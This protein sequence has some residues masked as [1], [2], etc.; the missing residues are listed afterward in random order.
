MKRFR[1]VIAAIVVVVAVVL[2]SSQEPDEAFIRDPSRRAYGAPVPVAGLAKDTWPTALLSHQ[3]YERG[4][5]PKAV[6]EAWEPPLAEWEHCDVGSTEFLREAVD[7]GLHL[8][9]WRRGSPSTVAVVFEGTKFT[10]LLDWRSNLRWFL[11]HL[12]RYKD[13]YT[14]LSDRFGREFADWAKSNVDPGATLV[15]TGHSLGGGLAQYFAYSLPDIRLRDGSPLRVSQVYAYDPSPVTGWYS[16]PH[17]DRTRNARGLL[18]DRMFE[19]GEILAYPRL[20]LGYVMPPSKENPRTREIR[21]NFDQSWLPIAGHMMR[22]L[23]RGL[24]EAAGVAR[25]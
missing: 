2:I 7:V 5:D 14:V 16:V 10:S 19:H 25:P 21:V 9:V 23:A 22:I 18:I 24:A 12:P 11:H 6:P 4:R 15:S 3:V 13:Q 20:L 17:A 1:Y 8:E